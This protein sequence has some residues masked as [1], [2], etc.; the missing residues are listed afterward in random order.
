MISCS[1]KYKSAELFLYFS[2]TYFLCVC[3]HRSR[4]HGLHLVHPGRQAGQGPPMWLVSHPWLQWRNQ[5]PTW[6]VR[7]LTSQDYTHHLMQ[8]LN[9]A[10]WSYASLFIRLAQISHDCAV[11]QKQFFLWVLIWALCSLCS[12]IFFHTHLILL[13]HSSAFASQSNLFKTLPSWGECRNN[14]LKSIFP[15]IPVDVGKMK[16][17]DH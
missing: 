3:V 13:V 7:Y 8:N 2:N 16:F 15:C 5:T 11:K 17:S 9:E 14:S 4:L 10:L 12:F 1:G 6:K